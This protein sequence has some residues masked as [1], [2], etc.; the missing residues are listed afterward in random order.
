MTIADQF[1]L[2]VTVG[3]VLIGAI[4]IVRGIL[5]FVTQII[6]GIVAVSM[7]VVPPLLTVSI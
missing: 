2:Q 5:L 3:M 4:S 6:G 7:P 1:G